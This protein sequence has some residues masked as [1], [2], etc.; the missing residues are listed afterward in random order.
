MCLLIDESNT[1]LTKLYHKKRKKFLPLVK[2]VH[3][4]YAYEYVTKPNDLKPK[5]EYMK[6]ALTHPVYIIIDPE[7]SIKNYIIM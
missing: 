5:R 4:E 7:G 1:V 6:L 3:T 2:Y